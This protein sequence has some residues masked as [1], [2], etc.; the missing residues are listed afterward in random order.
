MI[1]Y[2]LRLERGILG[3]LLLDPESIPIAE[4]HLTAEDFGDRRNA[5]IYETLLALQR[6]GRDTSPVS[7][8][9]E[10]KRLGLIADD[11]A[12]IL[13]LVGEPDALD[14]GAIDERI[15]ALLV[16]SRRRRA[17][18][19]IGEA[20][21][22]LRDRRN[23]LGNVLRQL[24]GEL[25]E[26]ERSE[27]ATELEPIATAADELLRQMETGVDP[28]TPTGLVNLDR[29]IQ[30]GIKPTQLVV[31]AGDTG[32]GKTSL[33]MEIALLAG[34]WAARDLAKRGWILIY[35]FEMSPNELIVR[36]VLQAT[37]VRDGYH[38]PDGFSLRDRERV[39]AALE[40][41][42]SLPIRIETE[43]PRTVDAIRASI[44]R[45]M[46]EHG[47]PALVIID[48]IRLMKAPSVRGNRTEEVAAITSD[49][50][51][52]AM[53]LEIPVLALAQLNRDP[54]RREDHR[55]QLSDLRESGSIEQDANIVLLVYRPSYY[56]KDPD[57]RAR[58]E[59]AGTEA[60]VYVAKNR[61]GPPAKVDFEW[62]GP[63]FLFRIPASVLAAHG[64]PDDY[65]VI[66]APVATLPEPSSVSQPDP[67]S[68]DEWFVDEGA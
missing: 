3:I 65:G 58:L 57:E 40:R 17:L 9:L 20:T 62:I 43:I 22:R 50:K 7:V 33:A 39:R 6:A 5:Q 24:R 18:E 8:A 35:S 45:H 31:L 12:Y 25:T 34:Q 41:I 55:P 27:S 48:H 26:I 14:P 60:Y 29:A 63:R 37:N 1:D 54:L 38:P 19:A 53:Q 42:R 23:N 61:S 56:L 44:E 67:D 46:L 2:G 21:K 36:L 51:T 52:M 59:A 28:G 10:L 13:D 30:G 15:E 49:L 64:M 11:G 16:E 47:R 4:K 68:D 32:S 66:D